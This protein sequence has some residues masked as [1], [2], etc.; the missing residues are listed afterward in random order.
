MRLICGSYFVSARALEVLFRRVKERNLC[1][2]A[3]T[4]GQDFP[5]GDFFSVRSQCVLQVVFSDTISI[6]AN[7]FLMLTAFAL[8]AIQ[9]ANTGPV[10]RPSTS[11][12]TQQV[13]P[14][15]IPSPVNGPTP[16]QLLDPYAPKSP[17]DPVKSSPPPASNPPAGPVPT[18]PSESN[19]TLK[20]PNGPSTNNP[21]PNGSA[22]TRPV[23]NDPPKGVPTQGYSAGPAV[24]SSLPVGGPPAKDL[25][26]GDRAPKQPGGSSPL[27]GG[28]VT[29]KSPE[30]AP[31]SNYLVGPGNHQA[32]PPVYSAPGGPTPSYI[33]PVNGPAPTGA[34][35]GPASYSQPPTGSNA[36]GG[37]LPP[38]ASSSLPPVNGPA[39]TGAQ[40]GPV[41]YSPPPTDSNTPT[42]PKT[43]GGPVAPPCIVCVCCIPERNRLINIH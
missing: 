41:P 20:G 8:C 16:V 40:G 7:R 19:A 42:D 26:Q 6:K 2:Q 33:P 1:L 36:P 23:P 3:L 18:Y 29:N 24:A 28:P 37:P 15:A 25:P 12:D 11:C 9:L 31:P 38:P 5:F 35:G 27:K 32:L 10:P 21:V 4:S 34:Q 39:P 22:T 13:P 14:S 43:Q 17:A 30:T